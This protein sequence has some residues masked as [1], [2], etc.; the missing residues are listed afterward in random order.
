MADILALISKYE[1]GNRNVMNYIGDSTH[2]AQGYFQLTN[3]NWR[4]L[5]PG[6]G[7][8]LGQYPTAM[9]A[10]Y[11]TQALVANQLLSGPQA[12]AGIQNWA[13]YNPSLNAALVSQGLPTSGRLSSDGPTM[14]A[15]DLPQ[16]SSTDLGYTD[17]S[18]SPGNFTPGTDPSLTSQNTPSFI[19]GLNANMDFGGV[20][21]DPSGAIAQS[22]QGGFLS[23][24]FG[25]LGKLG[26]S[27]TSNNQAQGSLTVPQAIDSQTTQEN[28][29]AAA[30]AKVLGQSIGG[31]A[32]SLAAAQTQSAATWQA[33]AKNLFGRAVV[34]IVGFIFVGVGLSMFKSTTAV[35]RSVIPGNVQRW[36]YKK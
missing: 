35:A 27:G 7:V 32:G 20:A 36:A 22:G 10:P 2:T 13:N 28:K 25:S 34:I 11:E 31:A 15:G 4:N 29:Q 9:T 19:D 24:I 17:G 5:A 30:D 1:S 26:G 23:S 16:G 3:T 18:M 6:L 14:G 21:T 33:T 12:G 8:D